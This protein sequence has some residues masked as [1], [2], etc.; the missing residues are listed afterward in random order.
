MG[1]DVE[2]A[3]AE[4]ALRSCDDLVGA[5]GEDKVDAI[6]AVGCDGGRD[7]EGGNLDASYAV[8]GLGVVDAMRVEDAADDS[9]VGNLF[10]MAIAVDEDGGRQCGGRNCL[11]LPS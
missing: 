2:N 4:I 9:V 7:I 11:R 10:L 3:D 5:S 1:R 8:S 6:F